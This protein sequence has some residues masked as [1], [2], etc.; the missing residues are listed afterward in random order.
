MRRQREERKESTASGLVLATPYT[1][2]LAVDVVAQT[3][4][5]KNAHRV[6]EEKKKRVVLG[7][8]K[9]YLVSYSTAPAQNDLRSIESRHLTYCGTR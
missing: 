7:N 5:I 4:S 8:G 3:R 2:T 9:K 1:D 6:R